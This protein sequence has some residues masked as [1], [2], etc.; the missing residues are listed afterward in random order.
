MSNEE[1]LENISPIGFDQEGNVL[2]NGQ[3][4]HFLLEQAEKA[5][6]LDNRIQNKILPEIEKGYKQNMRFREALEF[7]ADKDNYKRPY[8]DLLRYLPS[9]MDHDEGEKAMEVLHD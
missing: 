7:Y 1:R 8:D 4:Y 5:Q 2:V 9:E 6:E 3:D